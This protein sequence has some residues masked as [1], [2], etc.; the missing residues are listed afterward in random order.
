MSL[1]ADACRSW[2]ERPL[3]MK[4]SHPL[5]PTLL[6]FFAVE[7]FPEYLIRI[8]SVEVH[9]FLLYFDRGKATNFAYF[10]FSEAFERKKITKLLRERYERNE[11]QKKVVKSNPM[12]D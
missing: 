4:I 9:Y 1:L 8:S 6:L 10:D 7:I 12:Q 11:I 3:A 2:S 5:Y